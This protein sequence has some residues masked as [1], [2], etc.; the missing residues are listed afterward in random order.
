M[1]GLWGDGHN[2]GICIECYIFLQNCLNHDRMIMLPVCCCRHISSNVFHS[3]VFR[4]YCLNHSMDRTS[5]VQACTIWFIFPERV[6]YYVYICAHIIYDVLMILCA[7]LPVLL[8]L[9]LPGVL[10]LLLSLL[11]LLLLLLLWSLWP[12]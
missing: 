8:H 9:L 11:L 3:N 5:H 10:L 7:F 2:C 6:T 4:L 1:V 12:S